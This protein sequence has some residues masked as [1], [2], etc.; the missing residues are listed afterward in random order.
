MS[1]KKTIIIT[2]KQKE[3]SMEWDENQN[4]IENRV[5]YYISNNNSNS[6][7]KWNDKNL[8]KIYYN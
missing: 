2:R 1:R 3:G 5:N 4:I 7:S 6:I 8:I